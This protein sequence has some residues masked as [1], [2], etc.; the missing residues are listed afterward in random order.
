MPST[1]IGRLLKSH[2]ASRLVEMQAQNGEVDTGDKEEYQE[3]CTKAEEATTVSTTVTSGMDRMGMLPR[4]GNECQH[5]TT[6][7]RHHTPSRTVQ[8]YGTRETNGMEGHSRGSFTRLTHPLHE[9]LKP[10]D[11]EGRPLPFQWGEDAE[12]IFTELKRRL[13]TV[14][15]PPILAF[16]DMNRPFTVKPDVC[17]VSVGGLLIQKVNGKEVVIAY[18]SRALSAAKRNYSSVEREALG[19][20]YC[21]RQGVTT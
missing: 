13:T 2:T 17:K 16:L 3:A 7:G 11:K 15:T 9:L 4:L 5:A 10:A 20:V 21:C 12:A 8:N 14:V 1:A 18:T 6:A 19:L